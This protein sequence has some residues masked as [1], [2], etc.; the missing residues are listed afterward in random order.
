MK[1]SIKIEKEVDLKTLHV[2]TD[3]RYWQGTTVNGIQ[4]TEGDLIPCRHGPS[5]CPVID[6]ET[7]RITNWEQ[8]KTADVYYDFCCGGSYHIRDAAGETLLKIENGYAPTILSPGGK[9]WGDCINMHVDED[10]MIK[11]W[12]VDL[13]DFEE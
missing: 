6:I 2:Q 1:K 9:G 3:I 5:W 4:D 7:G 13:S 8:G 10:G 12:K 11:N